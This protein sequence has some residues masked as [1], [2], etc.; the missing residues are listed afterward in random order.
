MDTIQIITSLISSI[1]AIDIPCFVLIIVGKPDPII[2]CSERQ[3]M[4]FYQIDL[5][6]LVL[7]FHL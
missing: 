3:Q 6:F 7:F 2:L 1:G 4:K 5:I